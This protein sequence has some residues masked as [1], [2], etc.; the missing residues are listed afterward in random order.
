MKDTKQNQRRVVVTGM[1]IVAPNGHGLEAFTK[2]LKTQKSGLQHVAAMQELGFACQVAGIPADLSSK[3][4]DYLNEDE[5]LAMSESM[6]FAAVAAIDAFKS[7]ELRIP[8]RDE[9]FIYEDTGA[10]VGTGIGGIDTVVEELVPKV[11][12]GKIRRLG[13]SIIERIMMS[14]ISAKLGGLL[15]L[16]NQ[17]SSN[18][19]ACST[20]TEAIIMGMERIR[21]GFA[22]RMVVGG[23]ECSSPYTWAG[24]DAM[25]VL[26]RK[27]N[28]HPEQASRPMSATAAGF[29]PA[30]GAGILILEDRDTALERGA[31]IFAEILAGSINCGG[32]RFGGSMTAPSA[33][34]V[35]ASIRNCLAQAGL[36]PSAVDYINGHLTGT[37]ADPLEIKNW[38]EALCMQQGS[39]PLINSTKSLIGHGLGAAGA[40]ETIATVLQLKNGFVHGSNNCEDLHPEI[41]AFA[42]HIASQTVERDLEVAMKASFGFGDV[43]SCLAIKR[44]ST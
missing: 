15:G 27:F 32:Q 11:S 44:A 12:S 13:S 25:R 10:I 35:Q 41:E 42:S 22:K 36:E 3:L 39:T 24:F 4:P 28:E 31:P 34:G 2:A 26:C 29:I 38:A 17:V 16:G 23:A 14:S 18:S 20:G 19:S 37:M 30:A 5:L 40:I 9:D 6:V 1:G 43:N 21:A 7:A 33:R 8:D